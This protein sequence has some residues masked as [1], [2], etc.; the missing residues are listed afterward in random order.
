MKTLNIEND[1]EDLKLV[2]YLESNFIETDCVTEH[3]YSI[4][5][6]DSS[7]EYELF[8]L[9]SDD[10]VSHGELKFLI[11]NFRIYSAVYETS[12]QF[13]FEIQ[14]AEELGECINKA[15]AELAKKYGGYKTICTQ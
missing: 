15:I 1:F 3:S 11:N 9:I 14:F 5:G 10:L 13:E 8:E 7:Y 12:K 4:K 2:N 6:I